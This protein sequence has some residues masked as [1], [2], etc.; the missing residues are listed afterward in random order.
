MLKSTAL[1]NDEDYIN[2]LTD[3]VNLFEVFCKNKIFLLTQNKD[4]FLINAFS[5]LAF[6]IENR[7]C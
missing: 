1:R 6:S 3:I 7:T 4:N 2:N 5:K